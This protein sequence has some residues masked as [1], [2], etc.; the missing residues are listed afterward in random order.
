MSLPTFFLICMKRFTVFLFLLTLFLTSQAQDGQFGYINFDETMMLMPEYKLAEEKLQKLQDEYAQENDRQQN[1]F[2][3]QYTEY[4]H[5]QKLLSPT[6]IMKRQKELQQLYDDN[7]EFNRTA[8]RS[9]AREREAL[10]E[11]IKV[12]LL[13]AVNRVGKQ[14]KLDY[15]IDMGSHSYLYID[16]E[17]GIDISVQVYRAVGISVTPQEVKE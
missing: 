6:I 15:V 10:L 16:T 9:L 13:N 14:M 4:L 17:K 1:E 2:Y 5:G 12:K 3:R 11:P 7:M 8:K